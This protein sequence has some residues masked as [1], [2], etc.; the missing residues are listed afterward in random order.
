VAP[1]EGETWT[2][3]LFGRIKITGQIYLCVLSQLNSNLG[4]MKTSLECRC[5]QSTIDLF[6]TSILDG[7]FALWEEVHRLRRIWDYASGWEFW[8]DEDAEYLS[9]PSALSSTSPY[10]STFFV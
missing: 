5:Y 1:S 8:R 9:G 2:W 10:P 4:T 3:K 6:P 7:I